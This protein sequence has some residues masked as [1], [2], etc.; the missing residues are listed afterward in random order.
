MALS[1]TPV[2]IP[3]RRSA[4]MVGGDWRQEAGM[5]AP[6]EPP[7]LSEVRPLPLRDARVA[8]FRALFALDG[9]GRR[10]AVRGLLSLMAAAPAGSGSASAAVISRLAASIFA[11]TRAEKAVPWCERFILLPR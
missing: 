1:T 7:I 5:V 4:G 10:T 3:R 6:F 8:E 2:A 9:A 11:M